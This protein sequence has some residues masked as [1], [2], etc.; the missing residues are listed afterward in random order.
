MIK[1]Q[2]IRTTGLYSFSNCCKWFGA[3]NVVTDGRS[4][5]RLI[6]WLEESGGSKAASSLSYRTLTLVWLGHK[7]FSFSSKLVIYGRLWAWS[8]DCYYLYNL[9]YAL[10]FLKKLGLD[11]RVLLVWG[12]SITNSLSLGG[13]WPVIA[14]YCRYGG[15]KS[16]KG[17]GF[18]LEC[19]MT[20]VK[21]A[22][23]ECGQAQAIPATKPS[24]ASREPLG[25]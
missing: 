24:Q 17:G 3:M 2:E 16:R 25:C 4:C 19:S 10:A 9:S 8:V 6:E 21:R 5:G 14:I 1:G 15:P 12:N 18:S 7:V 23:V 11:I 20:W 13:L 22:N